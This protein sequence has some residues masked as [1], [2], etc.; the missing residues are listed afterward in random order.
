M[1]ALPALPPV[2][3]NVWVGLLALLAV[4]C[5]PDPQDDAQTLR[6]QGNCAPPGL[7]LRV[8]RVAERFTLRP[9]A[10][11]AVIP[12]QGTFLREGALVRD[13]EFILSGLACVDASCSQ[14]QFRLCR[15]ERGGW[16]LHVTCVDSMEMV[17]CQ[18]QLD[19]LE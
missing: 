7:Q 5:I 11:G 17:T 14:R 6:L 9:S 3:A 8:S 16:Q 18:G 19:E 12:L 15:A 1:S 4:G 2:R 10:S 13:G